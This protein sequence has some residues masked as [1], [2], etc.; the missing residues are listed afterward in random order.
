V[1]ASS[2]V[3]ALHNIA[4]RLRIDSVRATTE[5]GSG[6]PTSCCSAA[7][8][9]AA[10]F[11]SEMRYDPHAANNPDNDR[12]VLSKGHA[13]PVLYAAWAEA[14][15]I[16]RDELLTL[17]SRGTSDTAAAVGRRRHRLA[18]PGH[19]RCRR[20]RVERASHQLGL[21]HVCPPRG[22]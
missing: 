19:L 13:A 22:R 18:R 17:R 4:T 12:F 6:H 7:D 1:H 15:I 11:F 16:S 20:H 10:I 21:P 8:L 5:A 2:R 9:M 3:S 14:G